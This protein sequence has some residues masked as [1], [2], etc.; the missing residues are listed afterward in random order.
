MTEGLLVLLA[1]REG[2]NVSIEVVSA[3]TA[4]DE[5]AKLA[6]QRSAD[7]GAELT[8]YAVLPV[9]DA[10]RALEATRKLLR[11]S[12]ASF[13]TARACEAIAAE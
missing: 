2:G 12:T 4:S 9:A 10:P 3:G 8:T 6:R 7:S 13:A 5:M 11:F 1:D